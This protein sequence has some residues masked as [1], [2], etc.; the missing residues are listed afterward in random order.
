MTVRTACSSALIG[1]HEACLAIQ[2]G[3]CQA[4]IVG[5][6][7][8]ILAPGAMASMT[9][10]GVLSPDGSCKTF[11]ADANGYARGEAVTAVYIKPFDAAIRDGNPIRAVIRSTMSNNDGK[12][13][14]MSCP[15]TESQEA[16]IRKTYDIA[17]IT[18]VSETAFVECHGT[19]TSVGDP[20]ETNAV[21][22]VFGDKGVFIGSVKPNLGHSEGASGISSLIKAVLA[23]ENCTIPPNIKFSSPNPKIP[24]EDRRLVVPVEP[25]PWP[26]SRQERI[27]INSFGIGGSNA[28]VILDSARSFNVPGPTPS[29]SNTMANPHLLLFSASSAAS[30]Q[31]M[32]HE[33]QGWLVD[34]GSRDKQLEH[35]AYTLAH[36]R[37]H[38]PHRAFLVARRDRLGVASPG[39]RV[40]NPSPNVVMVFSGQGAQWPRMGRELLLRSDLCFQSRI[41]SLDKYLRS[42]SSAAKLEWSL[43][44]ELL[45]PA[46]MSRV[47][48]AEFS[49]PLCTAVQIALVDLFAA[50]GV[51]PCAVVGHSSGEIA[52]AYA[53]GALTAKEAIITAWQ[54]GRVAKMQTRPGA[55]AAVGLGWDEVQSFL[56][57]RSI[58][59]ACEN[60]PKSVTL[61][62]DAAEVQAT[63]SR[64]KELHP[65]VTARL[66]KVDKAYHSYHMHEI[67]YKYCSAMDGVLV[68]KPPLKP[69]F[70]SV[71][72][73]EENG[74]L[75]AAYWQRNLESPVLFRSAISGVLEHFDNVAF[76]EIGPHPALAGPVRQILTTHTASGTSVPYVSAMARGEDC[77]ESFLSAVGKLFE[78]N[79]SVDLHTLVP[80]GSCLPDL[81]RYPWDHGD[82]EYW[83]ESRVSQEWRR[84][85]HQSHPLLGIRQLESTSLE[86]SWR[87][88]LRVDKIGWLRD[89]KIEDKIIFPC[90]GYLAMA[91]EA[92]RQTGSSQDTF[93]LRHVVLKSAL[94]LAEEA[95]V[96]LVT[97]F[98]PSC[99]TDSLDSQWWDFTIASHNGHTWTKHCT[100]QATSD[101]CA[102]PAAQTE[103]WATAKLP[104]IV[105]PQKYYNN[106]TRA[107]LQ[108]GPLFQRLI[109]IRTG[110]LQQL[111]TAGITSATCGDENDYHLHPTVV[112]ACIQIAILAAYKGRMDSKHCRGVPTKIKR[113]TIGRCTSPQGEV[114]VSGSAMVTRGNGDIVGLSQQCLVNG[115]IAMHMEGMTISPLDE[116]EVP[117]SDGD[118]LC[119]TARL[120]WGP[121]IDFLDAGKLIRPSI[122]RH[123]Y[124]PSLDELTHLCLIYSQRRMAGAQTTLSHMQ[125]YR[126][127]VDS[128]VK[129]LCSSMEASIIDLDDAYITNRIDNLVQKMS[130]TPVAACATAVQKVT[131]N[132][133]ALFSGQ[134]EALEILLADDTLTQVY[135]ATDACDRSQ[136]IRHLVHSKPNLRILEIGAG[137]GASTASILRHL[138]LPGPEGKA[139]QPLYSKY[140]FTD[141]SSAFFV[142]AKDHFK[143]HR[144]IH[145]RTLDISKDPSAQG[146]DEDD[147]YDLVIATNVLHAT[148]SLGD[149]LKNVHK[150]LAPNGRL[151]LH[152]LYSLSKWPNFVFGTLPGWWYGEADGRPDEPCVNP[153]RWESELTR[154]GFDGLDTL[155]LDAEEPYQLNAIMVAKP[156]PAEP[157][158]RVNNSPQKTVTLVCDEEEQQN[159]NVHS[160]HLISDL[161]T[162]RLL[163]KGYLVRRCLLGDEPSE[164]LGDV[165]SLLDLG[166]R[167]FFQEVSEARYKALQRLL[168][169]L[170][171][172]GSSMLWVTHPCQVQCRDPSFAQIIGAARTIRTEML[173]DLATCEVD[174]VCSSLDRII[175]VFSRLRAKEEDDKSLDVDY[176]YAIVKGVVHVARTYPFS[177]KEE[178][179]SQ[180]AT[181]EDAGVSLDMTKPGRLGTLSWVSRATRPLKGDEVEVQIHAIGLNF[182]VSA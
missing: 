102:E 161:L 124:A 137:T 35:V 16:M 116:A 77:V 93:T 99:L 127:W 46:R 38:L 56:T 92:M 126:A 178:L 25:T 142:S 150:L 180:Q 70:S 156:Q 136:F 123:L 73:K 28:H 43:E 164:T 20:I 174:D 50:I 169:D 39:R 179:V 59:I 175:D 155:V 44:E 173:L 129:A 160:E 6:A 158:E 65:D 79:V 23:L 22:R 18:D 140:M 166:H 170:S 112:D 64:I 78:L 138:V 120:V 162:Q 119:T 152:E 110:T 159:A 86:P 103:T 12:T 139:H 109:D 45:K 29:S 97:T 117:G 171:R 181:P 134:T 68:G 143:L 80:M 83:R 90:A 32:V 21:A 67:G 37:E 1:L 34:D 41:R 60:S 131:S 82:A 14:G 3:H 177:L 121:H 146:F 19:G 135:I 7:N 27:S 24:F 69:F 33:F 182:K 128:Q 167:P 125:K 176:E 113:L 47:Q 147:K 115:T 149:S 96:E 81:P 17:G 105:E 153:T 163:A 101:A 40:P 66:L 144:N 107:G 15:S 98:R 13:P 88:I 2:Q 165:I 10:K 154:A 104:R 87:N 172:T 141:I 122:P 111:A 114:T 8:L 42:A 106:L 74:L 62:G 61:S 75:D 51:E 148:K 72:A 91:G 130:N 100:G 94:V 53:A 63:V 133:S 118:S 85:E 145:Y 9:E 76:L 57:P 95:P 54:R 108:F 55:M 157:G 49:Q 36:R 58:V 151:L 5:G 168:N 71:T 30:L 132:I 84:R 89:H 11:S 48:E 4:A 52:A 31:R 26:E